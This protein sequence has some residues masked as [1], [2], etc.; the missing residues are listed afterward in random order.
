MLTFNSMMWWLKT[1]F[2]LSLMLVATSV[3]AS[4]KCL[5][6]R[7]VDFKN[8]VYPLNEY[9]FTQG[10]EW[11]RVSRGRYEEPHENPPS[12]SFLYFEVVDIVFG[13]LTGDGREDAA[14]VTNYG[15]NSGSFALTD[16]YIFSCVS[17]RVKLIGILKQRQIEKDHGIWIND[18]LAQFSDK[19]IAKGFA[20]INRG[21]LIVTYRTDGARPSPEYISTFRYRLIRGKLLPQGSPMKRRI[22]VT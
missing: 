5:S 6:V 22:L 13:D 8:R 14:V 11:L 16:T 9:G 1:S 10:T 21:R 17:G 15:S 3:A 18:S 12:V 20:K 2:A 19:S 7:Q 4:P